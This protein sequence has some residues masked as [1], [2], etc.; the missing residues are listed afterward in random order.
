M[1]VLNAQD[2]TPRPRSSK[3]LLEMWTITNTNNDSRERDEL[4]KLIKRLKETL[5]KNP[6]VLKNTT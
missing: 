2:A 4:L 3:L 6:E 1:N 5:T